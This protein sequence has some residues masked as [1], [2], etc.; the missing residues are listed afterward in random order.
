VKPAPK[1]EFIIWEN[2]DFVNRPLTFN[3]RVRKWLPF[4]EANLSAIFLTVLF[5]IYMHILNQAAVFESGCQGNRNIGEEADMRKG[6]QFSTFCFCDS[7]KFW[8]E[9]IGNTENMEKCQN[10][11]IYKVSLPI[12]SLLYSILI[13]MTMKV[14]STKIRPSNIELQ[15]GSKAGSSDD[16]SKFHFFNFYNKQDYRRFVSF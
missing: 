14:F 6:A 15:G 3:D 16:K 13:F 2:L 7:K 10:F 9:I 1:P 8:S 5:C 12:F 11:W 4:L